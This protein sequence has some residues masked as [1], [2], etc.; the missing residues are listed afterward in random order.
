M[1]RTY[2]FLLASSLLVLPSCTAVGVATGVGASV[3]V[4]AA[5]EGGISR[6]VDDARIQIA[7]NELWFQY[8]V[9]TFR[10][11]DLTI[12]QGRVLITGVVQNPE[13]R[14]EAVRLA[15]QPEG[16]QQVINEIQIAESEGILGYAKDTWITTRLRT[17][18]TFDR[19]VNS[20]NYSID[21]V[22]GTVYL[23][24]FAQNRME[25]N[26]V[27]EKARTI[28]GV[29]GVVSYVKFVGG[30]GETAAENTGAPESYYQSTYDDQFVTQDDQGM[31]Q[32]YDAQPYD[33][34]TPL[35][36]RGPQTQTGYPNNVPPVQSE[37]L[38]EPVVIR[39]EPLSEPYSG[40]AS[41][42]GGANSEQLLW[43]D[44]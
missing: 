41:S 22:R 24:G 1:S 31:S 3:G 13:A 10:K 4:A 38:G 28:S 43:N 29:V 7:I 27:I 21:T 14:V 16:V 39:G 12:N 6:A 25:L 37:P 30:E 26:R 32:P 20:I 33:D 35:D 23:M 2:V 9:E 42:S 44:Q 18:L 8:D 36:M 34:P 40:G 19:N 5:Q 17:A 15:W 11:L